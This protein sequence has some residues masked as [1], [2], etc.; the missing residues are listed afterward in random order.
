M[1]ET[2]VRFA[3]LSSSELR[4][5]TFP[6]ITNNGRAMPTSKVTARPKCQSNMNAMTRDKIVRDVTLITSHKQCVIIVS[7]SLMSV[8][9]VPDNFP[10]LFLVKKPKFRLLI[11]FPIEIRSL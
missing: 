4:A 7:K 10:I 9:S 6:E 5:D 11:W 8:S 3:V 2:T 1:R